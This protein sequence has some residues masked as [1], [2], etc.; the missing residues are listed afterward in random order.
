MQRNSFR[1]LFFRT[2]AALLVS[3]VLG[4]SLLAQA[5]LQPLAVRY[6]VTHNWT[7][8]MAAVDYI[9]LQQR[10]RQSYVWGGSRAEWTLYANLYL[11]ATRSKY[12]DSEEKTADNDGTYAWRKEVYAVYRDFANN[13]SFEQFDLLGRAYILEDS[14]HHPHW[15]ILNDIKE[16]AGHQCMNAFWEDTLKKQRIIAWFALDLPSSAGPERFGGLPGLILELDVNNGGMTL[17]ADRIE[18]RDV[19]AQL[20][21]P[22]KSKGRKINEAQYYELLRK[23]FAEKK[24]AEE[25]PF[26]GIRY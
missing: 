5:D 24:A 23:H 26:W 6:L 14:L 13:R 2:G 12:E 1:S 16:V 3:W 18:Q 7:K 21:L 19:S 15:K 17:V 25:P 22:A 8:K 20:A 9:S 11:D 4:S 10:E